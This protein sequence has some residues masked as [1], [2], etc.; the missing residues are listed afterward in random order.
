MKKVLVVFGIALLVA[1]MYFIFPLHVGV[2]KWPELYY[3]NIGQGMIHVWSADLLIEM[4]PTL[5]IILVGGFIGWE[6][7]KQFRC[8]YKS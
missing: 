8:G 1:L 2:G 3:V 4:K 6:I 5:T 7:V